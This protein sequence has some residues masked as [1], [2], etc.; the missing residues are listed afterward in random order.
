MWRKQVFKVWLMKH[1]KRESLQVKDIYPTEKRQSTK[2][3]VTPKKNKGKRDNHNK[4]KA[5]IEKIE[6]RQSTRLKFIL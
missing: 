4:K 2:S 1:L 3:R 6:N 5:D